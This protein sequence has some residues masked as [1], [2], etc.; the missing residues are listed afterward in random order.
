MDKQIE[1]IITSNKLTTQKKVEAIRDLHFN[2]TGNHVGYVNLYVDKLCSN[3]FLHYSGSLHKTRKEAD[4][5]RD[6]RKSYKKF[7][8]KVFITSI[9][10][11][12]K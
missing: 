3:S 7:L 8:G 2:N 1:D 6:K 12:T 4:Y 10:E 11:K 9:K 5:Y